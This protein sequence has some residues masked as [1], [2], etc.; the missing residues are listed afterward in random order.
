[1]A[2]YMLSAS[3]CEGRISV[4]FHVKTVSYQVTKF[5][6]SEK[7]PGSFAL[8]KHNTLYGGRVF[9][10]SRRLTQATARLLQAFAL[11]TF[12]YSKF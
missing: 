7:T 1:M 10:F 3:S 12:S 9:K 11:S 6:Q 2:M 8:N 4:T 5:D